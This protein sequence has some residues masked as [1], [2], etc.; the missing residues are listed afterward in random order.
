[1]SGIEVNVDTRTFA[2]DGSVVEDAT[3]PALKLV[4][5]A[6]VSGFNTFNDLTR[7]LQTELPR[8]LAKHMSITREQTKDVE[9]M[10][11]AAIVQK[12]EAFAQSGSPPGSLQTWGYEFYLESLQ[13]QVA[14]LLGNHAALAQQGTPIQV[15]IVTQKKSSNSANSSPTRKLAKNNAATRVGRG[16]RRSG[17]RHELQH[18]FPDASSLVEQIVEKV[19]EDGLSKVPTLVLG[20]SWGGLLGLPFL[21]K[22]KELKQRHA[23]ETASKLIMLD[24]I[25]PKLISKLTPQERAQKIV[26]SINGVA[27]E[28][29]GIDEFLSI[30]EVEAYWPKVEWQSSNLVDQ[31]VLLKNYLDV[32]LDRR[33]WDG[34]DKIVAFTRDTLKSVVIP[35]LY[36]AFS[37]T[38]PASEELQAYAKEGD[39]SLIV[40][41][42]DTESLVTVPHNE[43]SWIRDGVAVHKLKHEPGVVDHATLLK[44]LSS[45]A[46][47]SKQV[48][49]T[50]DKMLKA[51]DLAQPQ[52]TKSCPPGGINISVITATEE[53]SYM[54]P[55]GSSSR[56]LAQ[57]G[58]PSTPSFIP[59]RRQLFQSNSNVQ[60]QEPLPTNNVVI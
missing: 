28:V 43:E 26:E 20:Y 22:I 50:F 25:H 23:S 12:K 17:E 2:P 4:L 3:V 54:S 55:I 36:A 5:I 53:K 38:P 51:S 24:A 35:N 47:I 44:D 32:H 21:K 31:L 42:S 56:H 15:C 16:R 30:E 11:L 9:H 34:N 37:F 29:I 8:V 52:S 58:G 41:N 49:S 7:K 46:Q 39:I 57:G 14:A 1:M 18:D 45:V 13:R 6:P 40:P 59:A 48:E 60:Q 10:L 27:K 33:N 19:G